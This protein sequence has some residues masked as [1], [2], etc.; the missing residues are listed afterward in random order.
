MVSGGVG[1]TY[2]QESSRV[3]QQPSGPGPAPRRA[4]HLLDPS[5]PRPPQQRYSM[6]LSKVQTWVLSTLAVITILH[7]SAGVLV[8]AVMADRTDA[9]IGLS[10]IAGMFGLFAVAAALAIHKRR[11]LTGWLVVGLVPTVVGLY[12]GFG[13]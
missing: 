7:M 9:R 3:D 2:E 13:R 4:R 5:N 10:V 1:A 12:L 11:L 6:S 8:A